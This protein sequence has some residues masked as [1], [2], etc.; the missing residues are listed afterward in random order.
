MFHRV[1]HEIQYSWS[2]F[3]DLQKHIVTLPDR[4]EV[5]VQLE[6]S[7]SLFF[8]NGAFTQLLSV[9]ESKRRQNNYRVQLDSLGNCVLQLN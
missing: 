1:L 9:I 6:R 7:H 4:I 2:Q 3:L 5:V 8:N